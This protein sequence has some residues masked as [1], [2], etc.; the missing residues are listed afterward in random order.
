MWARC[1]Y[2]FSH[3]HP[4]RKAKTFE[5]E[6]L[7]ASASFFFFFKEILQDFLHLIALLSLHMSCV[8]TG[9]EVALSCVTEFAHDV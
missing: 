1:M 2:M 4:L 5:F 7:F 3:L 6:H 8:L 9:R